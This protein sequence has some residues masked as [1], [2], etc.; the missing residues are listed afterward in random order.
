MK[1]DTQCGIMTDA[2]IERNVA[3]CQHELL[4]EMAE[5]YD[6]S[7]DVVAE[8]FIFNERDVDGT[9]S[10]IQQYKA[11]CKEDIK[12]LSS[13]CDVEIQQA[14][15]YYNNNRHDYE[16]AKKEC[17]DGRA[18]YYDCDICR[19][20]MRRETK[21]G[22]ECPVCKRDTLCDGCIGRMRDYNRCNYC[23]SHYTERQSRLYRDLMNRK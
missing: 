16:M 19:E 20:T 11:R 7:E 10:D 3:K 15:Y 9:I 4:S 2:D 23:R 18:Y 12:K 5:T 1:S 8:L 22:W 14:E 13:E 21:S 6:I 17:V